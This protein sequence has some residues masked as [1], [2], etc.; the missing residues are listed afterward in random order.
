MLRFTCV[1]PEI[2]R[3]ETLTPLY[4]HAYHLGSNFLL[5]EAYSEGQ[6][7]RYIEG[8]SM[9]PWCTL[10]PADLLVYLQSKSYPYTLVTGLLVTRARFRSCLSPFSSLASLC[11]HLSDLHDFLYVYDSDVATLTMYN[12]PSLPLL[13]HLQRAAD[14]LVEY[15]KDQIKD[16]VE[17]LPSYYDLTKREV[18]NDHSLYHPT[19]TSPRERCT[20]DHSL[21]HRPHQE[22]G[23]YI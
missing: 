2:L 13:S 4:Q 15:V 10:M 5:R 3:G 21:C 7:E 11:S 9:F 20:Y 14:A 17:T 18:Y 19:V 6:M 23:I 1:A 8:L 12:P 22:R 16:P